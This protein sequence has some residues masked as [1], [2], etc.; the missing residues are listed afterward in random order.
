MLYNIDDI[1]NYAAIRRGDF[2]YV[3]GTTDNG[4]EDQWYGD[5]GEG[6]YHYSEE[7][8]LMSHTATALAG[9]VTERQIAEKLSRGGKCETFVMFDFR[10]SNN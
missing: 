1:D 2:K 4:K 8:V 10:F 3:L 9:L 7:D 5:K 6:D